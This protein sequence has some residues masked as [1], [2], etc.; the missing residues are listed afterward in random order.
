MSWWYPADIN[1]QMDIPE[2]LMARGRT[3]RDGDGDFR[4]GS[5]RLGYEDKTWLLPD[6]W[7]DV[8]HVDLYSITAEGLVPLKM[9]VPVTD[10]NLLL[11]L[12]ED[13]AISIV[14]RR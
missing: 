11:T 1:Y 5:S 6:D 7:R 14:T 10:G 3:H 9:S 8:K 13:E 4:F 2:Y 12:E